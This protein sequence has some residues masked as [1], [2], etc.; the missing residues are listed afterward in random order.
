MRSALSKSGQSGLAARPLPN[1]TFSGGYPQACAPVRPCRHPAFS[2]AS[3]LKRLKLRPSEAQQELWLRALR[4]MCSCAALG[5][6]FGTAALRTA[7]LLPCTL[8]LSLLPLSLL[9]YPCPFP[10]LFPQSPRSSVYVYARLPGCGHSFK[11]QWAR[12]QSATTTASEHAMKGRRRGGN[13]NKRLTG[14]DMRRVEKQLR[15]KGKK[16]GE[17]G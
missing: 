9:P 13:P 1:L 3:P 8:P 4:I 5:R 15:K 11:T 2:Q 12:S 6:R 10:C 17:H 16:N 7:A 14:G